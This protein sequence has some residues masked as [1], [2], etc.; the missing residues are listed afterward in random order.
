MRR[1]L[2]ACLGLTALAS[3][4]L[5]QRFDTSW[6]KKNVLDRIQ[7][8]GN[9]T[10]GYHKYNVD[11]DREAFNTLNL[12]GQGNKEFTDYGAIDISG[13]DVLG[14]FN[15][16]ARVETGRFT[17]PQAQR[18]SLDYIKNAYEVRLG[19]VRGS[20]L[21]T[22]RFASF[23][24]TLKGATAGYRSGRFAV[25][26]VYSE[27]KG[28]ARTIAI[29]GN[30]SAGPYYLQ[31][32]QLVRGSEEVQLDGAVMK[33]GED[34]VINYELGAI[35]FIGR[36]IPPTST[37]VVTFEA[38]GFNTERGTIEGASASYD[39]GNAGRIGLVAMRQKSGTGSSLSQRVELFQGAGAASTPYFL[40]FEPLTTRPITV[41][42]D[43][44]LQIEGIDYTFDPDNPT[45]FYFTRFIPLTSTIE[46]VYTPKPTSTAVGDRDVVGFDY[47]LPVGDRGFLTY[48]T[49]RGRL[50]NEATP[51]SG[52][53]QG[54]DGLYR[55]GKY[56]IRAGWRDVPN[57]FVSVE[58]RGF[59]RNE[60]A[61]EAGVGF[62][63]KGLK[64]DLSHFDN[65][66]AVR[67]TLSTGAL[68]FNRSKNRTTRL[69][70]NDT[71]RVGEPWTYEAGY[72]KSEN[73]QG[74]SRLATARVG[75]SRDFGPVRTNWSLEAQNG[76]GPIVEGTKTVLKDIN[77]Q[78][79]R[80]TA[81]YPYAKNLSLNALASLSNVKV[82]E[83]SGLGRDFG[84]TAFY[85][86][87][88]RWTMTAGYTDSASGQLAAL[89][90]FQT[91]LGA[92]Y[93]GNGF[94]GGVGAT[95]FATGVTDY[96]Q[97][98][99]STQ[100]RLTDKID[101]N[102]TAHETRYAGSVSSNTTTQSIDFGLD[103]ALGG[104]T[105]AYFSLGNSD[106]R[107]LDSPQTSNATTLAA[108]ITGRPGSRFGYDV[109][110]N[111]LTS[112]G[113]SNFAQD[114]FALDVSMSYRLADRH[115]VSML[116]R[117][118]KT[119]GYLPQDDTLFEASYI[120]QIWKSVALVGTYR[121]RD[122][123]NL[124]KNPSGAYRANGFDLEL[125]F[126]F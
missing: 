100:Y 36:I 59:N 124:D 42:L 34:Y 27:A 106:T 105:F 2:L 77:L 87:S 102:L 15:F 32:G 125:R 88:S 41:R 94:S 114:D 39:F 116:A 7:I 67:R 71:R 6:I 45:I 11:G 12:Y 93:N 96:R 117:W 65:D 95:P 97:L 60:K 62:E 85:E 61:Y 37:I 68:S 119:S 69:T 31:A 58:T 73:A 19:D 5:A 113:T 99:L 104:D 107:F 13:R 66:V 126:G 111:W 48:S 52:T 101:V 25:K 21:N 33:L 89:N 55:T 84:L 78:T 63:T 38:F 108:G 80:M 82:G 79:V 46:V 118:G 14:L 115:A 3:P 98:R 28:S 74:E 57:G 24:K 123:A 53:A 121:I 30:N 76:R 43:G 64:W 26:G 110:L 75:T 92:G 22:N 54:I 16:Q 49:A 90:G 35:T 56:T 23:S 44:I 103:A 81:N 9:R 4:C 18:F 1:V 72:L 86:P 47:R 109:R 51:L 70:L 112:G 91:G 29:Q 17:D 20:L 8:S 83:D 120:Y 40:Q 50:K 10:L 122:V